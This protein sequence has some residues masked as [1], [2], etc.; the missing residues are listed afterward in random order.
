M[1]ELGIECSGSSSHLLKSR[2]GSTKVLRYTSGEMI[3][4]QARL[5]EWK[6]VGHL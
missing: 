4:R 2:D 1:V 6:R 5:K 3:A